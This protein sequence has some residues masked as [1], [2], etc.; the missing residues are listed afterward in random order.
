MH[1]DLN[2]APGISRNYRLLSRGM[3]LMDITRIC[4]RDYASCT[5]ICTLV[6]MYLLGPCM[7]HIHM[8]VL[9]TYICTKHIWHIFSR[10]AVLKRKSYLRPKG[11]KP[12][13]LHLHHIV[14]HYIV[15]IIKKSINTT[16]NKHLLYTK[17]LRHSISGVFRL[18]LLTMN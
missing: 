15:T 17:H 10:S 6:H 2:I 13:Y 3:Y 18:H 7:H 16:R 11:P 14:S 8:Y 4:I 5:Y 9:R 12:Q 1:D